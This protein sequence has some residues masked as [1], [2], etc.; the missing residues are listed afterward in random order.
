M[1]K[2]SLEEGK[3]LVNAARTAIELSLR[4][5]HLKN[6]IIYKRVSG[7]SELLYIQLLLLPFYLLQS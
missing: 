3:L 6:D 4:M 5:E 1:H 2:Y 7:L